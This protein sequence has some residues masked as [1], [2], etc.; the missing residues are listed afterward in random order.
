LK[1][2]YHRIRIREGDEW[3]TAFRTQLGAFEYQVVPFGLTNAPA[4]FQ[5][6]INQT[7][8]EYLDVFVIAY[9][10]DL[11]VY[12]KR[13]EDHEEHVRLVLKALMDAGLYCKLS[14]CTF[15]AREIELLGYVVSD[16]GVS[17]ST[18]RLNTILE[19]PEPRSIKDIQQF[20]GFASFYRRFVPKFS[21][22][23]IGLTNMLKG[24]I[25]NQKKVVR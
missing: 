9:L 6:Y 13:E 22:I 19:W 25:S 17:M 23:A 3:K 21:K 1:N 10:D 15:S 16:K 11:V 24:I 18:S 4:A 12:S 2:A 8:R 7:L 20:I 14:K 5:S